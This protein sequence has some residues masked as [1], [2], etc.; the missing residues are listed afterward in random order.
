MLVSLNVFIASNMHGIGL[1]V[2]AT[3]FVSY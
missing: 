2:F 3:L 1:Q